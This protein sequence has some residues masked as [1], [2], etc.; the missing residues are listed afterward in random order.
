M[1]APGT[2][3]PAPRV[4]CL[5]TTPV[6]GFRLHHPEQ[7]EL[8]GSGAVGDRDFFVVDRRHRLLSITRTGAF[9]RWTASVDGDVLTFRS[10]DGVTVT[11]PVSRGGPLVADFSGSR[12]VP[13]H[14]ADGPWDALL[15]ELAGQPVRLVRAKTPGDGSDEH[16]V[17]LMSDESVA[18]LSRRAG[19]AVV[20][21]RR[22]RMLVTFS[23][24][25]A[26]EEDGW[27]RRTVS[28]GTAVLRVGGPV[29]RCAAVNRQPDSGEADLRALHVIHRYRGRQPH[30]SG[31][32]LNFGVY[33]RVVTP[34]T[35]RVGDELT[36][37]TGP[38]R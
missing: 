9:A 31:D 4:T 33:A 28:V 20:D 34:G 30:G 35:V 32:G 6:K 18:E 12:S 3:A 11:G 21:P 5:S 19:V 25:R 22:F 10:D 13:G 14:F 24:V 15:S 16:P 17:T 8:D 7:V 1:A 36:D 29:P 23:G 26:H 27:T 38:P 37:V 2:D